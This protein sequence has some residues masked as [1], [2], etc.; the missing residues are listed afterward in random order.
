MAQVTATPH[1]IV[2]RSLLLIGAIDREETVQGDELN[3]GIR[4]MNLMLASWGGNILKI[5][6]SIKESFSLAVGQTSYNIGESAADWSTVRPHD[7]LSVFIRSAD[8]VDYPVDR[9]GREEW[10]RVYVKGQ[11]QRPYQFYYSPSSPN[12]ELFFDSAPAVAETAYIDVQRDIGNFTDPEA[13]MTI[14]TNYL[15]LIEYQLAIWLAPEYSMTVPDAVVAIASTLMEDAKNLNSE[16]LVA[17]LDYALVHRN[18]A[19]N[20]HDNI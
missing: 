7:V 16:P 17:E 20:R 8:N 13:D 15:A 3:D 2:R 11:A 14:P 12:G 5:P 18:N 4:V 1:Q 19:G 10:N 6:G 9:I